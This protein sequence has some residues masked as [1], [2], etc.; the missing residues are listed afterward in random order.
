MRLNKFIAL[1]TGISRRDADALIISKQVKLNG[2]IAT[3]GVEVRPKDAI[4]IK[5]IPVPHSQVFETFLFHKPTGFVCSRN[6]QGSRTIYDLLPDHLHH[7][8][9][10]GRLDKD[11][12][13]L[14]LLTN[15]GQ[16][17]HQLT[18]PSFQKK[19]VYRI[20]LH[21]PL[22]RTDEQAISKKGIL[23]DDGISRLELS[24]PDDM[25]RTWTVTMHEGR[26]RQIRRTFATCGY[27]LNRLHRT[28]LGPY[29][30]GEL[31]PGCFKVAS[32]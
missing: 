7:L 30:I 11:S 20:N 15:D 16:L 5:G 25:R 22:T 21:K 4:T 23:L 10:V 28:Q 2:H 29:D 17:A 12:S 3:L 13:G 14:L 32:Q 26:N 9:P 1:Q 6:G 18:H 8:K 31:E 19:K 27:S 24:K